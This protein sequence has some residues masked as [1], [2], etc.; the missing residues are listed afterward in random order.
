MYGVLVLKFKCVLLKNFCEPYILSASS[1][2]VVSPQEG[3]GFGLGVGL[4]FGV[5]CLGVWPQGSG[6]GAFGVWCRV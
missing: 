4:G 6:L 2:Q 1:R 5:D 3:S